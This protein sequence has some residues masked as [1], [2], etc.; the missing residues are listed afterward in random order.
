MV[1]AT[2]FI[3]RNCKNKTLQGAP[4]MQAHEVMVKQLKLLPAMLV[5]VSV[6]AALLPTQL[7]ASSLGKAEEDSHR[8]PG[9][10]FWLLSGFNL[11]HCWPFWR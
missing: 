4:K 1:Y 7:P 11:V 3:V 2:S 6:P 5:P 10:S 9:R 8:M